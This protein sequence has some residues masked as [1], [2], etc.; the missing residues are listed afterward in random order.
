MNNLYKI[1]DEAQNS[2]EQ[3]IVDFRKE[4]DINSDHWELCRAWWESTSNK[5]KLDTSETVHFEFIYLLA[6]QTISWRLLN[7]FN[8]SGKERKILN[9]A[10]ENAEIFYKNY[11][12][13][14]LLECHRMWFEGTWF[15]ARYVLNLDM[16]EQTLYKDLYIQIVESYG[17]FLYEQDHSELV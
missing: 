12:D 10:I 16:P 13:F 5:L 2:A 14:P 15:H 17:Y 4:F 7:W 1:L 11:D 8:D 9:L 3:Y 6:L